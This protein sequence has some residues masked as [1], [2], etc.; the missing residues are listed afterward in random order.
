MAFVPVCLLMILLMVPQ[1]SAASNSEAAT[2]KKLNRAIS[3]ASKGDYAM[4]KRLLKE[5]ATKEPKNGLYWFNLGNV[6]YL[7]KNFKEASDHYAKAA[8]YGKDLAD[9]ARLYRAKALMRAGMTWQAIEEHKKLKDN[10]LPASAIAE[11]EEEKAQLIAGLFKEARNHYDKGHYDKAVT[12]LKMSLDLQPGPEVHSFLALVY[13]KMGKTKISRQHLE[14]AEGLAVENDVLIGVDSLIRD[15]ERYVRQKEERSLW[16]DVA[17]GYNT[18]AFA[19]AK[20]PEGNVSMRGDAEFLRTLKSKKGVRVQGSL[21][22]G[23]ENF[24]SEDI[25]GFE[26]TTDQLLAGS[27]SFR[28][29]K[30]TDDWRMELI[31]Y[32]EHQWFE[33]TSYVAV[34]SLDLR[35]RKA[36]RGQYL[37]VR[38]KM[39]RRFPVAHEAEYLKGTLFALMPYWQRDFGRH[40][41]VGILDFKIRDGSD[42]NVGNERLPL[43]YRGIGPA[44]R[45]GYDLDRTRIEGGL[46]YLYKDYYS[47]ARPGNGVRLDNEI[48]L[49]GRINRELPPDLNVYFSMEYVLNRSTLDDG[50]LKDKNYEQLI[51]YGGL[52]WEAAL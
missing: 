46:N 20:S 15:K 27:M 19:E 35:Y 38:T 16:L 22:V 14:Q 11:L 30:E 3:A 45:Y 52:E 42:L 7:A 33:G 13:Q 21:G 28:I 39:A 40:S 36:W 41:L 17:V 2:E 1:L 43:A 24:Y 48:I 37:G 9:V 31:P 32:Y 25:N 18:N 34:P 8:Q 26:K 10:R 4:A 6:A 5:L 51:V 12:P 50:T 49:M 44:I 23:W 29:L 47:T